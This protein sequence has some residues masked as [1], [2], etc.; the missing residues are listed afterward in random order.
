MLSIAFSS[1]KSSMAYDLIKRIPFTLAVSARKPNLQILSD[2]LLDNTI[3]V[4]HLNHVANHDLLH[5]V[6]SFLSYHY[7]TIIVQSQ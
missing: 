5:L 4:N 1:A 2:D 6:L 3:S 7:T